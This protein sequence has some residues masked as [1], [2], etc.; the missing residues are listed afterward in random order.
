MDASGSRALTGKVAIVTGG[1][2]GMG[3]EIALE[4]AERGA[5]LVV[6]SNEPDRD[7]AV[8][9]ECR[10]L[11]AS[12][13]AVS[14]D[15][16]DEVAVQRLVARCIDEFGHID[17]LV[18]AAGIDVTDVPGPEARHLRRISVE[19]WRRVIDVNL[20]GV[21]LCV[22]QVLGHMIEAG[23]GS[24]MSCSSGTVRFPE[25]GLGAY[26]SSKFALEGFTKVLAQEVDEFC[27]RVNTIQPGGV[28]DTDFLPAWIGPDRRSTM[29][30]PSVIRGLAAYLASEESRFITGRSLVA[31]EWNK[32]RGLV[33]CPCP[34]CAVRS[35]KLEIQWRGVTAL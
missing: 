4:Y 9:A 24:I 32:E 31:C 25:P 30:K 20:T 2:R 26:V 27:V 1:G 7:E 12:A 10:Q 5:G 28:T 18:A 35:A 8:V 17:V 23:S 22:R 34:R 6:S 13:L 19:Q 16:R 21:F 33:L 29:H 15:V 3:R 14:A 11:G